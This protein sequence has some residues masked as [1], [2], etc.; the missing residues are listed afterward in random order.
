MSVPI[1]FSFDFYGSSYT[2]ANVQS[3]GGVSF[4]TGTLSTG[5]S[6]PFPS[7]STISP[8][9]F[10]AAFWDD[11]DPGEAGSEVWYETRGSAGSRELVVQWDTERFSGGSSNVVFTV[12]LEEGTDDIR[13]CYVDTDFGSATYD[14]GAS[15]AAGIQGSTTDW[16]DFS[17]DMPDLTDGL[18][19]RYIHP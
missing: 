6:C 1:G 12:V 4:D 14:A 7:T 3:N 11:L 18:L 8:T 5:L 16:N 15:A 19:V 9:T 13:I 17:C 10:I 2:M